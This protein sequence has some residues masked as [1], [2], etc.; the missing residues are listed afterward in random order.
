MLKGGKSVN[1]KQKQKMK[2]NALEYVDIDIEKKLDPK[3]KTE[4]C[5][6]WAD[7]NFCVYG[8]KCRFAH[9]RQE[10]FGK[11]VVVNKYKLKD[12]N[13]FKEHGICMYGARCNFKHDERRL[14]DIDRSFFSLK[15]LLGNQRRL[16]VF[17]TLSPSSSPL[18]LSSCDSAGEVSKPCF[19]PNFFLMGHPVPHHFG[20]IPVF[21]P[22][23]TRLY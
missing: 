12:C 21:Q 5:K 6:S 8:N 4:M 17:E 10:L 13:S 19:V 9:G 2:K 16:R 14:S 11:P 20:Q 1:D 15:P 18:N 22:L 23:M 7:T 3:Y